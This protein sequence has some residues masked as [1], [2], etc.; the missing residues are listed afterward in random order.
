M[1]FAVVGLVTVI[2]LVPFNYKCYHTVQNMK[3]AKPEGYEFPTIWDMW[4]TAVLAVMFIAIENVI[5]SYGYELFVPYCKD[6]ND[7]VLREIRAKKVATSFYKGLYFLVAVSW[8]YYALL[9]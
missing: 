3:A 9:D 6:Q 2:G 8:G 4:P 7:K 5:K 1:M